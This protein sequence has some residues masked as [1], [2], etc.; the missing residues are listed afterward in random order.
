MISNATIRFGSQSQLVFL[1]PRANLTTNQAVNIDGQIVVNFTVND[2][3]R[4]QLISAE[5]GVET[6][7]ADL[8]VVA[9]GSPCLVNGQ[10]ST[11][12]GGM[13][14]LFER[15]AGCAGDAD[16]NRRNKE[17][18]AIPWWSILLL[19]VGVVILLVI[20]VLVVST[21]VY[22]YSRRHRV[23]PVKTIFRTPSSLR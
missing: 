13:A 12:P 1:T 17:D 5:A 15:V 16:D 19:V 14:V 6:T 10:L 20:L 4:V 21:A 23:G 22:R 18:T 2:A 3:L 7:A 11:E 9:S 8:W